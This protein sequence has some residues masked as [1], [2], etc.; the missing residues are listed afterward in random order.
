MRLRF[1]DAGHILGSASAMTVQENGKERMLI[2][3]GDLGPK[4]V[5]ILRDPVPPDPPAGP[6]LVV[7]ESTYGD[8]DHRPMD[9]TLDEFRPDLEGG[10]RVAATRC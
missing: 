5:P 9:A 3:S 6:D 4:D 8:R 7:L 1:F 10:D 2:F